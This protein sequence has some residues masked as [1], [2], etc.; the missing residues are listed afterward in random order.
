MLSEVSVRRPFSGRTPLGL[1]ERHVLP[2]LIDRVMRDGRFEALRRR[3]A[4]EAHGRVLEIGIGSGLNLPFY[5]RRV[6]H[7]TG[8]DPSAALLERARPRAQWVGF[9]VRLL[10]GSAEELP[11]PDASID[12]VVSSWTLCSIPDPIRTL[13]EIRR[14]LR[15][16]GAF[17]FVEHGLAPEPG[18]ARLQQTLT[19]LW[20][21]LAGGCHLDR[22]IGTLVA[23]AG[24]RLTSPET[25]YLL[26]GPRA[27]TYHYVGRAVRAAGCEGAQDTA[28]QGPEGSDHAAGD[29]RRHADGM[30][31]GQP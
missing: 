7:L 11:L 1:W 17:V 24:L 10:L 30:W 2:R 4:A 13:A 18:V 26:P 19:P 20:R 3:I 25:G 14:V 27:F 15:P 9:P 5:G 12:T 29:R 23:R 8:V 21:R 31:P 16:G 22:P 6:E 28:E